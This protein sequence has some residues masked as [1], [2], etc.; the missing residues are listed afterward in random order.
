MADTDAA[1]QV[2]QEAGFLAK[3]NQVLAYAVPDMP[4]GLNHLLGRF[5]QAKINIEY[6]YSSL[7]GDCGRAYMIFRVSHTVESEA[8]LAEAGLIALTQGELGSA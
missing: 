6:M 5:N 4:G 2:L 3:V 7:A 8:A 1:L